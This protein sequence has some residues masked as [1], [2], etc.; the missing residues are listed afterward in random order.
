MNF[1]QLI[2]RISQN[3]LTERKIGNLRV[4]EIP[5]GTP[6]DHIIELVSFAVVAQKYR[7]AYENGDD[8]PED[9]TDEIFEQIKINKK[10][11][12]RMPGALK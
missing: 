1:E 5:E 12:D 8:I 2:N 10:E 11:F 4:A 6:I 7:D 9:L 3:K